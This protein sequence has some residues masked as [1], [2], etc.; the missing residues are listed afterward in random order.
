MGTA[1][2]ERESVIS[3]ED[4]LPQDRLEGVKYRRGR[5]MAA[6]AKE[7]TGVTDHQIRYWDRIKLV[8]PDIQST[9]GRPGV[10]RLLSFD[11][12]IEYRVIV[13]CDEA[14]IS[15]QAYKAAINDPHSEARERFLAKMQEIETR[16]RAQL[17]RKS[18]PEAPER[19]IKFTLAKEEREQREATSV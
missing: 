11:N 10:V 17:Y 4:E 9:G 6:Q 13:L 8:T 18:P 15:L 7:F 12:L 3:L 2:K 1:V 19:Q 5:F 16:L 14:G